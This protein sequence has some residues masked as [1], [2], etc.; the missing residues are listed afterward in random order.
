M[1]P[2]AASISRYSEWLRALISEGAEIPFPAGAGKELA[3][4]QIAG[5]LVL[6]VPVAGGA[7]ILKRRNCE[8]A[9]LSDHGRWQDVHLGALRAAYGKTPYFPHLYPEIE[10][11]YQS[12]GGG[13]LHDFN[14]EIHRLVTGWLGIEE[15]MID[16][17]RNLPEEKRGVISALAE[18]RKGEIEED[19][20]I[21]ELL[22]RLGREGLFV[23]VGD[24]VLPHS[25]R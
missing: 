24:F 19:H 12:F 3:R 20:S 10:R 1:I 13:R 22:F 21:L 25:T 5:G 6:S 4:T 7:S 14:E 11:I 15:G 9:L 17:L 23:L 8:D 18:E 2:F 16:E